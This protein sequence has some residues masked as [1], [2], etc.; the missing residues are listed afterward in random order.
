MSGRLRRVTHDGHETAFLEAGVGGHPLVLV[1]GFTGSRLD[2]E[3]RLAELARA[4]R[5]LLPELRGHG[6]SG[7]ARDE[8]GYALDA[9]ADDLI[10]FL[11]ALRIERCD[12][13]GHSMGGMVALRAVLA[14]PERF[15]SLVCMNTAARTP[16]GLSR[17]LFERA[18]GIAREAGMA[19]LFEVYRVVMGRDET[20]PQPDRRLEAW[21]GEGYWAWRGANYRA[22]DPAAYAELGRAIF[23]QAPLSARL[24]EIRC[25]TLVMVG[26]AD[27][28]FRACADELAQAIPGARL[29]VISDAAHQPQLENPVA[30]T[31]AVLDHLDFV[32]SAPAARRIGR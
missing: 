6:D 2:F 12:L 29:L 32:R 4:G 16:D 17:E 1:H 24:A 21:L 7:H 8:A 31:R 18:A 3:P 26:E 11:D 15:A 27:G 19:K 20:R 25:P 5:T 23:E 30:W 13:L 28:G 14:R 22:M 9:L 10:G